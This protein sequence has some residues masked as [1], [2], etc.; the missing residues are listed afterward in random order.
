MS[1]NIDN[2]LDVN[3]YTTLPIWSYVAIGFGVINV[4]CCCIWK[5][6]YKKK[7]SKLKIKEFDLDRREME[8]DR[9]MDKERKAMDLKRH[10]QEKE[11]DE[12]E[13]IVLT[14]PKLYSEIV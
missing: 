8:I 6:R 11:Y 4:T 2:L 13:D 12:Y 5:Y 9:R 14:R 7:I 1:S 3:F 10:Q